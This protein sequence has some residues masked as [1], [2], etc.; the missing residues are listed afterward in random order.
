MKQITIFHTDLP[1]EDRARKASKSLRDAAS[2]ID[3]CDQE[4]VKS[5]IG[6]A[7]IELIA[8]A[9][10]HGITLTDCLADRYSNIVEKTG[11]MVLGTF[12]SD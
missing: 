10:Y 7:L 5:A 1:P 12:V 11:G 3:L 8:H 2:R 6:D 4:K 9:D